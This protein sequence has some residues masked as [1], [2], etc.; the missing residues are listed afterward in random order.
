MLK[1]R[2]GKVDLHS[3]M[4]VDVGYVTYVYLNQSELLTKVERNKVFY[5]EVCIGSLMLQSTLVLDGSAFREV[6]KA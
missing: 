4:L 1:G 5:D 2:L 3:W 6:P